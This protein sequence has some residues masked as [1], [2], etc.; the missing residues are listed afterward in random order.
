MSEPLLLI[1]AALAGGLLGTI[2]FGGLWW[3]V[4]RGVL[5]K[6]PAVWFLAS[7]LLRTLIALAGFYFVMHG[8]WRRLLACLTGFLAARICVIRLT[9]AKTET[10]N[11]TIEEGA[12]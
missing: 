10:R 8:D 3:T 6:Q 1:L 7:L 12:A 4:R 9:S 5:S 11:Q 2:F